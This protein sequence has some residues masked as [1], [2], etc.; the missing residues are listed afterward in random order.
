M[1]CPVLIYLCIILTCSTRSSLQLKCFALCEYRVNITHHFDELE[2]CSNK[3]NSAQVCAVIIEFDYDKQHI[4][5]FRHFLPKLPKN[6]DRKVQIYTTLRTV[7][8]FNHNS[9]YHNFTHYCSTGTYCAST[10]LADTFDQYR[11]QSYTIFIEKLRELLRLDTPLSKPLPNITCLDR[12]GDLEK[13]DTGRCY[14]SESPF[15]TATRRGCALRSFSFPSPLFITV[16]NMN[17][18]VEF[19]FSFECHWP[20]CNNESLVKTMQDLIRI[21]LHS[22]M[23]VAT[24]VVSQGTYTT[25]PIKLITK[26]DTTTNR[27]TSTGINLNTSNQPTILSLTV[28]LYLHQ[29]CTVSMCSS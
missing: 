16:P 1:K 25:K 12:D 21:S 4:H 5:V 19:T 17:Q 18:W 9:L 14:A 13:C 10:F 24:T 29:I 26:N 3:T 23:T 15:T 7:I 22:W 27:S 11:L 20:L 6:F 8:D 28:I 2:H